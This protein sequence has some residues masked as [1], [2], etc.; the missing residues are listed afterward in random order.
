MDGDA[1][2]ADTVVSF[3]SRS[4][5]IY[6][7]H[8]ST[9][10][11]ELLAL[12]YALI[13]Y[14]DY[15]W[16]VHFTVYTDHRALTFLHSQPMNRILA[17][18]LALLLEFDFVVVHI[19]GA[20]NL[21]PDYLSRAYPSRG[22][23]GLGARSGGAGSNGPQEG[24]S[25]PVRVT[26]SSVE[27]MGEEGDKK[28]CEE[29][30]EV[31]RDERNRLIEEAH[32]F[33]HF[34][35][36]ATLF[37]LREAGH[38][39]RGMS[40][41][42]ERALQS[43]AACQKWTITKRSFAPLRSIVAQMPWDHVEFDLLTSLPV[44]VNGDKVLLVWVD[45]LSSYTILRALPNK[46]ATTLAQAIWSIMCDHGV[47]RVIQHDG[48]ATLVGKVVQEMIR[49][50]GAE[51]RSIA[52]Y[53]PREN[54]L[55]ERRIGTVGSTIRK[56]LSSVGG[57]WTELVPFVQLAINNRRHP[58]TDSTPFEV[59]HGRKV[60]DFA[61]YVAFPSD[62]PLDRAAWIA[63]QKVVHDQL[64]PELA[65]AIDLK[66][67]KTCLAFDKKHSQ[68]KPIE[69]GTRVML[70]DPLRQS[71]N[72][73]PYVGPYVVASRAG[74]STYWI[75]DAVG[76]LL[77]RPVPVDQL[78]VLR[79]A[80]APPQER[81]LPAPGAAG[82]L[83]SDQFYVD[84]LLDHKMVDGKHTYLVKWSGFDV[85]EATWVPA[86]DIEDGLINKF[87]ATRRTLP[88]QGRAGAASRAV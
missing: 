4:L 71:K 60:N 85:S 81:R 1:P 45:L 34:G 8:Y 82:E 48:E 3:T 62:Y 69:V 29:V 80:S 65:D 20:T 31:V 2:A 5:H 21:G 10:K 56:V 70:R 30:T 19:P 59:Y 12:V 58:H 64:F 42:V 52:A 51:H 88:R 16:G 35:V 87:L 28:E 27:L 47:P 83:P 23:W 73:P 17:N 39:W 46:S 50:H 79:K 54:G 68:A 49:V 25:E 14:E 74:S 84:S 67:R 41:M 55:V 18:W 43:C 33:G 13:S 63:H 66:R 24:P 37:K 11:L 61:S 78:K 38:T 22:A 6:E 76:G 26:A 72:E 77:R 53:N 36:A 32:S 57:E 86:V 7:R 40:E 75:K 9:Y 15:V 44:S